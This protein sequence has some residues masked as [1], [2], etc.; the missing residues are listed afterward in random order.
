MKKNSRRLVGVL[1]FATAAAGL[2]L[3]TSLPA[4]AGNLTAYD[5]IDFKGSK[6]ADTGVASAV[7]DVPDDRTRS[8]VNGLGFGYSARNITVGSWSEEVV[9][10]PAGFQLGNF[11]QSNDTVDHFD[12]VG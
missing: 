3:A 1:A 5:R 10:L 8:V 12:R 7:I 4:S 9:Y 2:V 11:G 6:L